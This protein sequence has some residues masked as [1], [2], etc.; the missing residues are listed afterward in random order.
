MLWQ[1]TIVRM[2]F[3]RSAAAQPS[4]TQRGQASPPADAWNLVVLARGTGRGVAEERKGRRAAHVPLFRAH[5]HDGRRR[6]E[7]RSTDDES[8]S[9]GPKPVQRECLNCIFTPR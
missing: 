4:A 8:D 9:A 5:A 3:P 1:Q 2:C 7:T 6:A